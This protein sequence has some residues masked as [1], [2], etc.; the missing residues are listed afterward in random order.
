MHEN[1][2]KQ[3]NLFAFTALLFAVAFAAIITTADPFKTSHFVIFLAYVCIA[4]FC[5]CLVSLLLYSTRFRQNI[6]HYQKLN[7]AMR[8]AGL[9][10]FFVVFS[11]FLSS[12]GLSYWWI[13]ATLFFALVCFELF[14][15]M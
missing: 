2:K 14:F 7:Q 1:L 4:G 5:F 12:K 13:E 10:A 11:L 6:L 9:F 8:E 15:L 3:L